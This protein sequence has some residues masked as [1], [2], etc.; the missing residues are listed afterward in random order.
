MSPV[1]LPKIYN[2][3]L[4]TKP[5]LIDNF[6]VRTKLFRDI[7]DDI[8]KSKM[9]HPEQH[10]I[11]QGNRGQ[12]KTTMLLRIAYEINNDPKLS[13]R[14][15][16]VIFNEEQYS[17][18][19]LFKLWESIAEYLDEGNEIN[20]LYEKMQALDYDDDY[21]F[22]C[23]ELL[24]RTLIENKKKLILFIDNIDEMFEKFS[25]K[26]HHRL[27]EVF[28]ESAEIRVIGASSV[29]LEFHHDYGKPFYHF[30]KMPYLKGLTTAETK[31]LLLG[32]GRHYKKER[33]NHIVKN[34]PGRIEALRR[35]TGGVI[36]TIIILF[37]IFVD[38]EN[39]NAFKD[40]E[41][42]L[43]SVTPL[44]K[45]RMDKLSAQQQ[46]IV[47][48][49]ALNWDAVT[50]KEIAKKTRI[51][52]KAVSAQLGQLE[53]FHIIEKEKTNTK[54]YLYRI[55]ERFFNIWYLM[56]LGRKWDER[57]VRFIV[58]FLQIWCDEKE[59]ESRA[60]LH[61]NA[62]KN[63]KINDRHAWMMTEALVRTSLKSE[64]Q[65]QLI[66]NTRM[67]LENNNSELCGYLSKCED[68]INEKDIQSSDLLDQIKNLEKKADKTPEDLN[69]LGI[70]YITVKNDFK[71]AENYFL[72][73]VQMGNAEAMFNLGLLYE[74]KIKDKKKAEEYYLMAVEKS[75]TGAMN[76][77]ALLYESAF[78]DKEKA[79]KYFL[80]AVEKGDAKAMFNLG[81][82]YITAFNDKE[83]SEKCYLMAVEKGDAEAMFNLAVLY[84]TAFKDKEQAE[85]YYL[86]AVE[87]GNAKAMNNLAV[88]Y[89]TAFNDNEKAE[90]YYL[91]ALERGDA[92]AMNNLAVFYQ[93]TSEDKE[94]VEEYF[95][96][97]VE[98]GNVS[99]MNNLAS[100]YQSE[101]K[102][103]EK[104]KRYYLL[105]VDKGD[106]DAMYKLGKLYA[107]NIKSPKK[108]EKYYRMAVE[109]DHVKAMNSLAGLY[110]SEFKN[111]D[112]TIE[113]AKMAVDKGH[114]IAMR[115]LGFLYEKE[116]KDNEKAIE[117]FLMA[118]GRGDTNSMN[119]L[120]L[121]YFDERKNKKQAI[122]L[123]EKAYQ[124]ENI[125]F[126]AH[127]HAII[128]LWDNQF[129]EVVD[130][131]ENFLNDIKFLEEYAQG[132]NLFL[133]LLIAKKQYHLALNIFSENP[134]K[135]K[136]RFKPIY[137]ALM[138]FM[139]DEYPNE[140]LKMGGELKETVDE[141]ITE[142]KDM[143]KAYQ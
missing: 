139:K 101:F 111:F 29:S 61:L 92:Q 74:K 58:E 103:T 22:Q 4:Q 37:E 83:K 5:E 79:E 132:V 14:M 1:D 99:A 19:K 131:S 112:K 33:V 51:Q 59:L 57:R 26:E 40:L 88:I 25:K 78:K 3:A 27:R 8:K 54:N 15:I 23:F 69:E 17:I 50:T 36:R 124:K 35:L 117:Y 118:V 115:N 137:Y 97:A 121:M 32:L 91:M 127:A 44:Y 119:H 55:H 123:S 81:L 16:S 82:I 135:F 66:K 41:K 134:H 142:I 63:G 140:Y 143:E 133:M 20:G 89:Q 18:T 13:K 122:E 93:V 42:I 11:I 114:F 6:V 62:L 84:E 28:M 87:K 60:H 75:D 9:Q 110:Y 100:L 116:F 98:K 34:Q 21:E 106:A 104:A 39:G 107:K 52:S 109:K 56:R 45:H 126:H 128:L 48:F 141:I 86:M 43:D 24:E 85:E 64:L 49:I 71:K 73:A 108:A 65:S 105:A 70:F 53:K 136:D 7:F 12:G 30:F 80:M 95:L 138:H 67:L 102:D 2:P 94:K 125:A 90:K 113:Y 72:P 77:L 46:E 31:K 68:W 10:Y 96:M 76:N 38:D 120:A 129:E 47:D 130:I